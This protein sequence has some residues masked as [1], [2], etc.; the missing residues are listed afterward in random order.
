MK[1]GKI[2][3]SHSSADKKYVGYIAEQFGKDRCVYDSLCFEAGMKSIDEIYRELDKT[4]IFV[5]FL[6]D[7]SLN[8]PWVREELSIAEER[9]HHDGHLLSQCFPIIIDDSI[10]HNDERI[11]LWLRKGF[12]SYNLRLISSPQIAYRKIK[13]QQDR[14]TLEAGGPLRKNC[15]YGRDH[16]I[17]RFKD[18]FDSGRPIKCA[19]ASGLPRMGRGSYLI[20]CLKES[21]II[22][23]YYTPPS[24]VLTDFETIDDLLV[25]ISQL[26][27]AQYTLEDVAA[28]HDAS[29]KVEMLSELLSA[30]QGYKDILLIYDNKN[31]IVNRFGELVPWFD[32]ALAALRPELTVLIAARTMLNPTFARKRD[33]IFATDIT[34][35]PRIEWLGLLRTYA[36]QVGLELTSEDREYF[37]DI[38]TGYPPQVI[39]VVDLMKEHG[40]DHIKENPHLVIEPFS[41]KISSVL[42]AVLSG[43]DK[44]RAYGLLAFLSAYGVV[45]ND[46][47][48]AVVERSA[49][50]QEIFRMLKSSTIVRYVGSSMETVEVNTLICDYIQRHR[51][52]IPSDIQAILDNRLKEIEK[53]VDSGQSTAV[54]DFEELKYYLKTNIINGSVIPER[55]MYS[56][57]YLSSVNEL[58]NRQRYSQVISLVEMLKSNGSFSRYDEPAQEVMQR[59]YCQALARETNDKFYSEVEFFRVPHI[60]RMQEE[61]DFLRGFMYRH[62][63]QYDKALQC[64]EEVL[65]SCPTHRRAKREIVIVYRGLEDFDSAYSY[66]RE[67]YL[68]DPENPFQ[69]QP[70]F[71][72]LVRRDPAHREAEDI[73]FIEEMLKTVK[74]INDS[75][76]S[77]T[78]YEIMAQYAAYYCND[79]DRTIGLLNTGMERYPDSSYLAKCLFDCCDHFGDIS[80][81]SAALEKLKNFAGQNKTANVAYKIR[82]A[83]FYAY[84]K[85]P[86]SFVEN[87]IDQI[88]EINEASKARL[89]KKA[90]SILLR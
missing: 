59:L 36:K 76:P 19:V 16:E 71:E 5:V 54:E 33:Y 30:I 21:H 9:L 69:I 66:A 24:L 31:C 29:I 39:T 26:G 25:K 4:S 55:F 44:Q 48:R 51:Y 47:L 86:K 87:K 52:P 78:Y 56:T 37:N 80:G 7:A 35:L 88:H 77:S 74:R 1:T 49:E 81:M 20:Q 27:F 38:L 82:Q 89:K 42:D 23:A 63:S 62:K 84:Q 53:L 43:V 65:R 10:S 40:V 50:Y 15:F 13:A 57:L 11:P 34:P 46:L 8:S 79:R 83:L 6:S 3:L 58:Y 12:S 85:K 90:N 17:K 60:R 28:I 68:Q 32:Q 73:G 14:L 22:E 64:Y 61:Y 70:F 2:F 41:S 45:P 75:K 72:I 18:A 67:N